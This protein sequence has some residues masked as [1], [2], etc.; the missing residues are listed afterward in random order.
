MATGDSFLGYSIFCRIGVTNNNRCDIRLDK[1]PIGTAGS[2]ASYFSGTPVAPDGHTTEAVAFQKLVPTIWV[3]SQWIVYPPYSSSPG[4]IEKL[5]SNCRFVINL[6]FATDH[7][8]AAI[9]WDLDS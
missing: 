4:G 5:L 6:E 7:C 8:F 9:G 2:L 1:R 3:T